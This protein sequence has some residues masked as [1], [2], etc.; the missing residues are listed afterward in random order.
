M[1][2]NDILLVTYNNP[3]VVLTCPVIVTEHTVDSMDKGD[4]FR[5]H[6]TPWLFNGR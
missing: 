5:I 4:L 6:R 3:V 2:D 1:S